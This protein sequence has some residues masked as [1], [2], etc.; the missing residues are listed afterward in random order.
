MEGMAAIFKTIREDYK[1]ER[2]KCRTEESS[3]G[4]LQGELN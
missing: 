3:A 1:R 2:K 4:A